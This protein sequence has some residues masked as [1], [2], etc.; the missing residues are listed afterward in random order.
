[1]KKILVVGHSH[2]NALI[3]APSVDEQFHFISFHASRHGVYDERPV[4][5]FQEFNNDDYSAVVFLLRGNRHVEL[6]LVRHPTAPFDFILPHRPDLPV[7][8]SS[9]LLPAGLV[10]QMLRRRISD[11]FEFFSQMRQFF[12]EKNCYR[13]ESPPPLPNFYVEQYPAGFKDLIEA[14]GVAPESFRYKLWRMNSRLVRQHCMSIGAT[15]IEAPGCSMDGQGFLLPEYWRE[16]PAHA[17]SLYGDLVLNQ[18][19]EMMEVK[20]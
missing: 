15:F 7:D 5:D 10:E 8:G 11:E 4:S 20:A 17:N 3:S 9:R 16:D 1:M 12:S 19:R 14:H 6:G 13:V 18:I 2:M